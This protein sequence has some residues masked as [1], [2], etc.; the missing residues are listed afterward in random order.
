MNYEG[1]DTIKL[2]LINEFPEI[3][4]NESDDNMSIILKLISNHL[5]SLI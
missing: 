5:K 4:E 2:N 3:F 1:E